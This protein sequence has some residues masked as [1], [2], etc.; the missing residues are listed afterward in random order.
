MDLEYNHII[1]PSTG[2]SISLLDKSGL[3]L[4]K[5]YINKLKQKGG[6]SK[7]INIKQTENGIDIT[8]PE[9]ILDDHLEDIKNLINISFDKKE[10]IPS[11]ITITKNDYENP[12]FT[13]EITKDNILNNDFKSNNFL[14]LNIDDERNLEEGLEIFI[15]EFRLKNKNNVDERFIC[16]LLFDTHSNNNTD[17]IPFFKHISQD[18][19]SY[20]RT[21]QID[22]NIFLYNINE[23]LE[24]IEIL[25]NIQINNVGDKN[26]FLLSY[27]NLVITTCARDLFIRDEFNDTEYPN[28]LLEFSPLISDPN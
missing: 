12:L 10:T 2:Q 19:T 6:L 14:N 18:N 26:K 23:N 13:T 21:Q 1:N 8:D 5:L 7:F 4:L 17:L 20:Y 15:N 22:H 16:Y 28:L 27:F 24:N 3:K 9:L 11:Q 25:E